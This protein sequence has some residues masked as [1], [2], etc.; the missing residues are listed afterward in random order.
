MRWSAYKIKIGTRR[1]FSNWCE[2]S[3]DDAIVYT[4]RAS[5]LRTI[6]YNGHSIDIKAEGEEIIHYDGK[7]V[8]RKSSL[9]G[10]TH[11]FKVSESDEMVEDKIKIGTRR[12]FSPWCEVSRD[13][14][15]V[16]TERASG[17]RKVW[18]IS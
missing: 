6:I 7:E 5:G 14:A 9:F 18:I 16:Y 2:V 13:D 12:V 4:E 1:V 17:L 10:A 3:R 8:S 11:V 15:I